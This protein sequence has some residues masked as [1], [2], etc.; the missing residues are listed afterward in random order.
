MA[1]WWNILVDFKIE[2]WAPQVN[3]IQRAQITS[4]QCITKSVNI[5]KKSFEQ[6][7]FWYLYYREIVP[8]AKNHTNLNMSIFR[9]YFISMSSNNNTYILNSGSA[10]HHFANQYHTEQIGT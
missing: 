3:I 1:I 5:K 10:M 9:I 8:V 2:V 4:E 7:K 6:E